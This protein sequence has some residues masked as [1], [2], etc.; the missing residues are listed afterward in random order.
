MIQ[1]LELKNYRGFQD[2]RLADLARVNLLVG[3][4]NSGKTSVLQAIAL[5]AERGDPFMFQKIARD[6]GES[7]TRMAPD[8]GRD[9]E[10]LLHLKHFFYGHEIED[11]SEF[12]II[13]PNA[14]RLVVKAVGSLGSEMIESADVKMGPFELIA[15]GMPALAASHIAGKMDAVDKPFTSLIPLSPGGTISD[16]GNSS[17]KQGLNGSS[18]ETETISIAADSLN[19]QSIEYFWDQA[20]RRG[21]GEQRRRNH[22]DRGTEHR[23][24]GHIVRRSRARPH[25]H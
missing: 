8:G 1:S 4:N 13:D 21:Q 11:G 23:E 25:F 2:Y 12:K 14:Q 17:R 3:R 9:P 18:K 24:R 15:P 20:V 5:L 19:R 16:A 22:E 7:F 10:R 6:R